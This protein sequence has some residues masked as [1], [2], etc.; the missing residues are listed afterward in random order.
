MIGASVFFHG[1]VAHACCSCF[2]DDYVPGVFL[3]DN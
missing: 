1:G 2:A 3:C